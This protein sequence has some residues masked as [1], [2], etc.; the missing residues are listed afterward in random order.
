MVDEQGANSNSGS[1]DPYI[2]LGLDAN[3][4]YE[5]IKA[6]KEE[7]I[8]AAGEDLILKAK[9]ESAYDSLLMVSLKQRQSGKI[10]N[11]AVNASERE[12]INNQ[13]IGGMG[14]SLL[15]KLKGPNFK[16]SNL[17]KESLI[18]S[19]NVPEGQG[20]IIRISLAILAFVLLLTS[21]DKS[22]ELILSF[23]TIGLF[24]SQVKRGR[25]I[26]ASLGWSV[27][28]LSVGLII[29]GILTSQAGANPENLYSL[30]TQKIE[31]LPAL[32]LLFLGSLLL[33]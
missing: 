25:K 10:S 9:I 14:Q 12:K 3:A 2:M 11:A 1:Q 22:I 33:D 31:A 24:V 5:D 8:L 20:L 30:S 23:S 21:S 18:P 15:T 17:S 19:L 27:V 4:S 7:K 26:M 28:L 6:A 29:G 16:N 32:A 13:E